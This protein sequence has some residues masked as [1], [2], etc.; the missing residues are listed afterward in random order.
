MD[1]L[2]SL[3][4]YAQRTGWNT[5]FQITSSAEDLSKRAH[6]A[7]SGGRQR[8]FILGGDGSFQDLVNAL[9]KF[10]DIIL[11]ILPAGCGNDLASSLGLPQN[12]VRAAQL[13]RDAEVYPMDAVSVK[14]S[15]G[16][17]RLYTGGGG[18]GLDA[19][20]SH[21]AATHYRKLP[22]RLRYLFSA[23]RA[24]AG[25]QAIQ[26]RVKM[27]SAGA[28]K[29]EFAAKVLLLA[30]LNTP[31]YG[32]GLRFAPQAKT[33]DGTLDLVLGEDLSLLE[34]LQA[35]PRLIFQGEVHSRRIKRFSIRRATIETDFPCRF[36]GDGEILGYTPVEIEVV[37]QAIRI[38]RPRGLLS[39]S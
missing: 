26:V 10:P 19:D 22:G 6:A 31:S 36:H 2:P 34:I 20:A 12:P 32:A 25:F 24:F 29:E 33:N 11:G 30:V 9:K 8:I 21:I 5:S 35:L 13:L 28:T 23:A 17:Q 16:R 18:V 39:S 7:A 15:D 38:L 14:T 1:A 4:A 27:E 37:P 3:Q